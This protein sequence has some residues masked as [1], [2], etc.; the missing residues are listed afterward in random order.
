MDFAG[1]ADETLFG[2]DSSRF[3]VV[4]FIDSHRANILAS[5]AARAFLV[6]DSYFHHFLSLYLQVKLCFQRRNRE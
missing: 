3:L 5:S 4:D 1:S 2:F 6:V